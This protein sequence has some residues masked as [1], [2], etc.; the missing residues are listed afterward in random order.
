MLRTTFLHLP[1]FTALF[2]AL[3]AADLG[4]QDASTLPSNIG[5]GLRQLAAFQPQAGPV[6]RRQPTGVSTA[7]QTVNTRVQRDAS[8]RVVV[9]VYLAPGADEAAVAA[10]L[11]ALGA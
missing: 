8:G 11:G 3:L 9:D 2:I 7:T 4:A 6:A 1:G 10:A 5:G